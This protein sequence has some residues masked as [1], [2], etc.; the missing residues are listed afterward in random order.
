MTGKI[1]CINGERRYCANAVNDD[2][3]VVWDKYGQRIMDLESYS[4]YI[5]EK[6]EKESREFKRTEQDPEWVEAIL[7]TR[8]LE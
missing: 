6:E 2:T 7:K 4:R 8:G 3:F 5:K 1:V